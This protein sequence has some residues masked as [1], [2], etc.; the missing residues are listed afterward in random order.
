MFAWLTPVW[1]A[2][3]A[4][5]KA[6][7]TAVK[8]TTRVA[9]QAIRKGVAATARW[10]KTAASKAAQ[11]GRAAA[12]HSR[13]VLGRVKVWF[14]GLRS[15]KSNGSSLIDTALAV[16]ERLT[17]FEPKKITKATEQKHATAG[18][19]ILPRMKMPTLNS[20]PR[21]TTMTLDLPTLS[22]DTATGHTLA[23]S[24]REVAEAARRGAAEA[25]ARAEAL[26]AQAAAMND[27]PDLAD[28]A[29]G[30]LAEAAMWEEKAQSRL[31][32]ASAYE[33]AAQAAETEEGK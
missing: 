6:T 22:T 18:K 4:A 8:H 27:K 3:T 14:G 10:A 16:G 15:P 25:T 24:L 28:A 1:S 33:D 2:L 11:L 29:A 17:T 23:K 19:G 32:T 21:S 5:A 7:A 30:L 31:G 26:R 12:Q 20:A 13:V 9:A